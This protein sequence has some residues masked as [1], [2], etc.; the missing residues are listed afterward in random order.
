MPFGKNNFDG[1]GQILRSG[2]FR[3]GETSPQQ[4]AHATIPSELGLA[5]ADSVR[6]HLL[7]TSTLQQFATALHHLHGG[8]IG[9]GQLLRQHAHRAHTIANSARPKGRSCSGVAAH[10]SDRGDVRLVSEQADG[11]V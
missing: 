1:V 3:F 5:F 11:T 10:S 2:I 9:A 4:T 8:H 6:A 7:S